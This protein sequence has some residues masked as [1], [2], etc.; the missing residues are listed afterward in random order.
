M[1]QYTKKHQHEGEEFHAKIQGT[2]PMTTKGHQL[3][4]K[5]SPYDNVGTFSAETHPQGSAPKDKTFE[6]NYQPGTEQ[7]DEGF[8]DP[9]D[10]PG[11]TSQSVYAGL[12]K[13]IQE[14]NSV[15]RTHGGESKRNKRSQEGGDQFGTKPNE[16][17]H[18][19]WS[20]KHVLDR[21]APEK[22]LDVTDRPT[23]FA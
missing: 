9:G 14:Q 23:E 3:G 17:T 12:G 2:D 6:P 11:S 22:R 10:V 15:E 18:P 13:P 7:R 19:E 20:G 1:P 5:T 16:A 8:M 4:Q 21:D